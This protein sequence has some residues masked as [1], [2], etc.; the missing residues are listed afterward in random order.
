[1]VIKKK[2]SKSEIQEDK[3][4][5]IIRRGGKSVEESNIEEAMS[6]ET[7][8]TLRIPGQLLKQLD[9]DRFKRVGFISRNQWILEAIEQK[10]NAE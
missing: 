6:A 5:A 1:M 2:M 9:E 4:E 3:A 7:R 10:M 8:F